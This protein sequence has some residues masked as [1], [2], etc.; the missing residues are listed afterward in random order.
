[1]DIATLAARVADNVEHV[2]MGKRPEVERLLVAVLCRGHVL[3]E[4]VPGVG[5]TTLAKGVARSL[6]CSFSRIQCTPDLL[7]SDITGISIFNQQSSTFEY[8]A[9][10]IV[11]QIVLADEIN[12]AT[13]TAASRM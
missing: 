2:I 12:R 10:P 3:I 8:R 4:D 1:M 5:K 9:G 7:P 6:G 13:P 11:A